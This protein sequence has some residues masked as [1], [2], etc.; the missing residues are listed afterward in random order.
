MIE[1]A[2]HKQQFANTALW[3]APSLSMYLRACPL[4]TMYDQKI[5]H[6]LNLLC[7]GKKRIG[8]E[9]LQFYYCL[10]A[11]QQTANHEWQRFWQTLF[12]TPDYVFLS[13]LVSIFSILFW[14]RGWWKILNPASEQINI[15]FYLGA[16]GG[17]SEPR[18]FLLLNLLLFLLDLYL[19]RYI[20]PDLKIDKHLLITQLS[21]SLLS[22]CL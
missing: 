6:Q 11:H 8:S 4:R 16:G 19:H 17:I 3:Q 5:R 2:R 15:S 10:P 14:T 9:K 12:F 18:I 22:V 7:K 21:L 1:L 13:P 20:S